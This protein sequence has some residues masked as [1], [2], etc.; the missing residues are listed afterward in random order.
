MKGEIVDS[1][2]DTKKRYIRVLMQKG[3]VQ[4]DADWNEQI[5]AAIKTGISFCITFT[6]DFGKELILKPPSNDGK[7]PLKIEF[8]DKISKY[9]SF[10]AILEPGPKKLTLQLKRA[11]PKGDKHS[12]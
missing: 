3:T 8:P 12:H 7:N 11:K 2:F 5:N 9:E 6:D 10:E 4:V 1:T